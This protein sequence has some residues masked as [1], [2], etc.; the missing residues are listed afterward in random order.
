MSVRISASIGGSDRF[1]GL[2]FRHRRPTNWYFPTMTVVTAYSLCNALGSSTSEVLEKCEAGRV[3]T[4]SPPIVLP[5]D[6]TC[7]VVADPPAPPPSLRMYDSRALRIALMA[8]DDIQISLRNAIA[9]NGRERIGLVLGTSTAGL[10]RTEIALEANAT[11]GA[12]PPDYS[13]P[14][15]HSFGGML[16]AL[17][18]AAGT[19]GPAYVVS[20]ACTSSAKA[21]AAA[22]R[23]ISADV[24][25]AVVVGGADALCHTTL[26]GFH[27]LGVLSGQAC[28]PF[29]TERNG[30]HIGEGAAWLLLEREGD[31]PAKVSSV[32]ESSDAHS[33]SAPDPEGRGAR[34]AIEAALAGAGINA[35]CID[36]VNAHGTGTVQNDRAEAVAIAESLGVDVPVASTKGMTGHLLGAAGATEAAL[37]IA[38]MERGVVPPSVGAEP[39]DASLGIN[40]VCAARRIKL[41]R[42]L[43]LSMAFGGNNTAVLVES[44]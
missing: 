32:G 17:V 18:Q 16:S 33:M 22:I 8:M 44:S 27:S 40:V 29:S 25:D 35:S 39:F 7:G 41:R 30:I 10:D 11:S 15:Q 14:S 37:A 20:T 1:A 24:C 4:S 38:A 36:F 5:F 19:R 23:M 3:V 2:Q 9:K 34:L 42:A 21:L 6:T 28:R 12:M 43:S 31:G 26:H 13:F